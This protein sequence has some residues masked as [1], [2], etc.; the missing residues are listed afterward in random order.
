MLKER[1]LEALNVL[2]RVM[3]ATPSQLDQWGIPQYAI[4]RMLPKLEKHGL[5]QVIR[6]VRPNII[7]LTHK[8][9][10][11]VDQPLPS[12][13]SYTSWAV[14]AH[15]CFR[16]EVELMLR[17]HYPRF[18]FFSRKYAYARGLNPARG[19]HG[20][21]DENGMNYLVVLDDYFMQPRRIA[22]CWTRPHSPNTRYY[23]DT[24]SRRWR[25]IA[26]HLIV[27][28]SDTHQVQRHRQFLNKCTE[29]RC[30]DEAGS[31]RQEIR[32]QHG[33][34]TLDTIEQYLSLPEQVSVLDMPSLW[35][36]R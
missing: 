15:R 9:G 23:S 32:D 28:A 4:S 19:E 29:I 20:G 6:E 3:Y 10:S 1:E 24:A 21:S 5:V 26:D 14:M 16:N 12:G 30:M 13:K 18:T 7:A 36:L 34:K 11:V 22:H 8:G 17:K 25:D 31:P 2:G 35:E 33:L 27:V